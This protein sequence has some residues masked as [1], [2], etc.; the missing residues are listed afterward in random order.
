MLSTGLYTGLGVFCALMLVF[1]VFLVRWQWRLALYAK[2][3][4]EYVQL[5]NEKSLSLRKLADLETTLTELLDAYESLLSSHK[6][7]RSRIGMRNLREKRGNSV[8]SMTV[9]ASDA[10]RAAYKAEL[11]DKATAKGLLR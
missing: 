4:I 7:L 10:D 1:A 11:R 5:Q 3:A 6:K 2:E 9:P 8:D